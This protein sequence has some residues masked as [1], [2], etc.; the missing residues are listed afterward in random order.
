MPRPALLARSIAP[1]LFAVLLAA[2]I[3][4]MAQDRAEQARIAAHV[5]AT[6]I[7]RDDWGI[8]HVHGRSDADAVFGM[9]VAQAEDD[10]NRIETNYLV[11]LG[12]LAEAEGEGAIWSDL[13]QRMFV[14][15]DALKADYARAPGWLRDLMVAWADG[16]NHY[17][18]THPGTRPRVLTRFEPWMA[19]AFSEGSIGADIESVSLTQLEAFYGRREVAWSAE[20]RGLT[21][22]EPKGSNGFA[23]APANT[24]GGRPLLLI[25]P[26][27][28]FFFRSEA[29]VS[30]DQGLNVYGAS[31]WGQFFVYQ[32][33][34]ATAGW[35]HTTS[36]VD[37][38]DEFA[39]APIRRTR[40]L[41]YRY[42]RAER[43]ITTRTITLSYRGIGGRQ[44]QRS[45]ATFA[46]HHGPI[47]RA[48][49]GKW[50]ATA[51]MQRPLAAL[52]QSFQRTRARDFAGFLEVAGL[53][54]NST[55]NT[56]FADSRGTIA[57]LV[58]QFVPRR[59]DR[60][61][62]TRPV[63]GSD[64][65]TDW[66]GVHAPAELPQLVNP[67]SGWLQ[68]TNNWPWSAAGPGSLD[69]RRYPRYL[70]QFGENPRGLHALEVL[71]G[72][73]DFTIESLRAAAYDPHVTAFDTLIPPLVAAWDALPRRDAR[74]ARLARPVALLKRWDRRW[75]ATST[76]TSLAVFWGEAMWRRTAQAAPARGLA[77]YAF[78]A[79]QTS[80]AEKLAALDEAVT[81][82]TQ[83]FGSAEVPWGEINR[84]QRNDGAIRQ[85]FDDT[86]PSIP[87]PFTSAQW[88]SLAS[89]G[90]RA[91]P[92]TKRYYGT[93]G[94][95]FVAV[96][97][98]GP[99]GPVARAVSAG[100]ESGDPASPHF[101]DQAQRY[102]AGDL[103]PVYFTRADLAAHTVRTYRPGE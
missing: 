20:E 44:E 4:A 78:M 87:V 25:N 22:R 19:L 28:S 5:A 49:G 8:A 38:I 91:W 2:G 33:F 47:V 100:G 71:T 67:A 80:A 69:A 39:V 77:R 94:N 26:H 31:T 103:R 55:N 70:D 93:L 15:H 65:R 18:A 95:S 68:N 53:Q 73:R 62:Y 83:D 76:A 45:F 75:S 29:Q 37:S 27:T 9:M 11:A 35:M 74:R 102:A 21:F 1:A 57:F 40:G 46:T 79:E 24:R 85:R 63:D 10:F 54:A 48:E 72:K 97:E 41:F 23:I 88:G 96:V 90:A 13:R 30:S 12:R 89:F 58:P 32:G 51:L 99:D 14:D 7:T 86:K 82:L 50:I 3:P 52:Q 36:G 17:L 66:R 98:F 16:L 64:P 92:G 43:P 101:N 34:N 56:L 81:R 84:F 60:F 42:G 61:D 6:T 59:D